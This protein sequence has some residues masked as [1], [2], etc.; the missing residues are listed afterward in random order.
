MKLIKLH[1]SN[2]LKLLKHD[3][4]QT[5]ETAWTWSLWNLKVNETDVSYCWETLWNLMIQKHEKTH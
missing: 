5:F 4:S 1:V 3:V 2:I